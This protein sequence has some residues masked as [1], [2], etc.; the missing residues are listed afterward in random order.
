MGVVA[1]GD[2]GEAIDVFTR[3]KRQLGRDLLIR[4][5]S[6]RV[7]EW[8]ALDVSGK[9]QEDT[10]ELS[11][12]YFYVSMPTTVEEVAGEVQPNL[13]WAEEHFQER[14]SGTPHNPP[15]S[16]KN[17][18]HAQKG[19]EDH[20]NVK[21]AEPGQFSHTYPERFWAKK[22]GNWIKANPHTNA[23]AGIRY[24]YGDLE[25]VVKQLKRSPYTRQAYLPVWFPEDTGAVHGERVPCTLGYHFLIRDDELHLTYFIRSVDFLR[26]FSDDVYMAMRLAQWMVAKLFSGENSQP[27]ALGTFTMHIVS[28]HA[29]KADLP[30]LEREYGDKA[31]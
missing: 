30:K 6:V 7:P 1:L 10:L 17:W 18:P 29:F 20:V 25:D 13:P 5:N 22:A 14:V 2:L 28:L 4:G 27:Y 23:H 15:P 8:Q 3:V 31:K 9:P 21:R 24:L 16:A 19:H 11:N 26:H 12:V